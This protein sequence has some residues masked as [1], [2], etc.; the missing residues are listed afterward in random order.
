MHVIAFLNQKGGVG[1]TTS[2]ANIAAG[3]AVAGRRVLLVDLDPQFNLTSGLGMRL[4]PDEQSIYDVLRGSA[5]LADVVRSRRLDVEGI[6]AELH[7]VGASLSLSGADIQLAHVTSRELLLRRA[8]SGLPEGDPFDYV[9][10]D[11][12]PSLGVLTANALAAATQVFVPAEV[13]YYALEGIPQLEMAIESVQMVNE[14]LRIGGV[15]ATRFDSRRNLNK[16]V[17]EALRDRFGEVVFG[18]P[19]RQNITLAEAPSH[20]QTIFEYAPLSNGAADYAAVVGELIEREPES[21]R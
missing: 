6:D 11:C 16:E 17:L 15:L 18:T 19:I 8:L 14:S 13:E 9:L 2:C 7:L 5:K 21:T 1:K 10:I 4:G 12:P 20:G 3:L